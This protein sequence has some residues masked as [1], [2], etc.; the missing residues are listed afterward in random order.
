MLHPRGLLSGTE[1]Q[2]LLEFHLLFRRTELLTKWL[3]RA[4]FVSSLAVVCTSFAGAVQL[5]AELISISGDDLGLHNA[6]GIIDFAISP[7]DESIAVAFVA[8]EGKDNLGL[9]LA[10]WDIATKKMLAK[11]HLEKTI[12]STEAFP[13][14]RNKK[15][16]Y[17]PGGSLI[18]VRLG[19]NLYAFESA[20]LGLRYCISNAGPPSDITIGG[21]ERP[22]AISRDESTLAMLSGQSEYP[23]NTL[24]SISLYDAKSGNELAHWPAPAHIATLSLSPDGRQVLVTVFDQ[25]GPADILLL[26]S[27]SGHAIKTFVSGFSSGSGRGV[28]SVLFVNADHFVASPGGETNSKGDYFGSSLKEFDSHTGNVTAELMY[29]KFGPSGSVWVS[30]KDS[31]VATLN[32]WRSHVKRR[33]N[34]GEKGP[35]SA[36]FLFFH[37]DGGNPFCVVGP[38]PKR[39]EHSSATSGFIRFSPDLGLVGLFRSGSVTVHHIPSCKDPS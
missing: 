17:D 36:Q 8:A 18:L 5:P 11:T 2:K 4:S 32:L 25:T 28:S 34:P 16:Q 35:N 19:N 13:A 14:F 26:D 23:K 37:P 29:D 22:F 31:T 39:A 27:L 21:F 1:P 6:A 38:L 33:F 7:D 12:P 9:W 24:G 20:T 30:S 10:E 15:M 3:I